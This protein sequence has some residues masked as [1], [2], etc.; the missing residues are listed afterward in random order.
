MPDEYKHGTG[1]M[2]TRFYKLEKLVKWDH[3][4]EVNSMLMRGVTPREVSVWCSER[5]LDISHPKLYEYKKLL[6][7]SVTRSIT[8]GRLLGVGVPKRKPILLQALGL[9]G[10]KNMV[11][12]E[13]E[14]LDMLIHLG[15]NAVSLD[16]NIKVET[17]LKAIEL[18]N[19]LTDG[20]HGGLTGYGLDQLRDLERKKFDA[21]VQVVL[22]YIPEDRIEELQEA[23]EAAERDFYAEAAPELLEEYEQTVQD[24]MAEMAT[25]E[26]CVVADTKF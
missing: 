16:P 6:Q 4:D 2:E 18:K 3:V 10:I 11:K 17:A 5:G 9:G 25:G 20:K 14:L 24:E 8:V 13:L 12:N 19:K 1:V 23:L 7:E 22:K 26:D 15:M 21:M